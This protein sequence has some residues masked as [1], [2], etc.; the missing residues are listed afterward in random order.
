[1]HPLVFPPPKPL[2]MATFLTAAWPL[3]VWPF[4]ARSQ[5]RPQTCTFYLTANGSNL[6]QLQGGQVLGTPDTDPED[7]RQGTP[8]HLERG[9]LYDASS[10]GCWW[11]SKLSSSQ[12][13]SDV[14]SPLLV[15]VP[16]QGPPP[17]RSL[18]VG[19]TQS[20]RRAARHTVCLTF[21]TAADG[22]FCTNE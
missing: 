22:R 20:P 16:S 2:T 3:L 19:A 5:S 7:D 8:F 4:L 18:L 15:S 12:P 21:V 13:A 11:A 14:F 17:F 6:N 9:A 10:R 1:M